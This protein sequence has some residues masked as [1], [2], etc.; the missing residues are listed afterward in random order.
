MVFATGAMGRVRA[1]R[2]IVLID[3]RGA[4][5][6]EPRLRC[7]P[8]ASTGAMRSKILTPV[9]VESLRCARAL[10]AQGIDLGAYNTVSLARDAKRVRDALNAPKVALFAVSYGALLGLHTLRGA[11]DWVESAVAAETG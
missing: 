2:D 9:Q 7:P 10:E 8:P 4:G 5:Y 11:R 1:Q 3:P 6:S